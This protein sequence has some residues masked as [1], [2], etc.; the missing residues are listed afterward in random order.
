MQLRPTR[1]VTHSS[2]V[3]IAG[4][5]PELHVEQSAVTAGDIWVFDPTT[6]VLIAGDLVT[7]PAPF[8]DTACPA[9]WQ[10]ALRTLSQQRF[11]RLIS[12]TVRRWTEPPSIISRGLRSPRDLWR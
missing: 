1:V 12:D 4:R 2:S 8:F 11:A 7:L 3:T 9:R 10:T 6:Q 5:A